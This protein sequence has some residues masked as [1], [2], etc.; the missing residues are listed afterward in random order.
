MDDYLS[1]EIQVPP[2]INGSYS[3]CLNIS[4]FGDNLIEGTEVLV[5]TVTAIS[6]QDRVENIDGL[7]SFT[8]IIFDNSST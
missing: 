8:V 7:N 5:G 4:V 1:Q 3:I 2:G 6:D